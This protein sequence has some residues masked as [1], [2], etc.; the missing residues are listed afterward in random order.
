MNGA[1]INKPDEKHITLTLDTTLHPQAEYIVRSI[2]EDLEDIQ[3]A[4]TVKSES[5][6]SISFEQLLNEMQDNGSLSAEAVDIIKN[7]YEDLGN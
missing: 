5:G 4:E 6:K 2:L 3:A 7:R 1:I